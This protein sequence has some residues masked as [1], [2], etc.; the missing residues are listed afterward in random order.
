[1]HMRSKERYLIIPND[2]KMN[3]YN[4]DSFILPLKNF[5]VGFD[6]YFEIDEINKFSSIY[7][8][9]IIINKLLHKDDLEKI[10]LELSKLSSNIKYIFI[11][12]FSLINYLPKDKI[13]IYP[14]HIITNYYS[15]NYLNEL[16]FKNVCV[17][18]ELTINELKEINKNVNSNLFY[19][20]LSKNSLMY[21]KRTLLTNYFD[22]YELNNRNNSILVNELVSNHELIIK[23]EPDATNVFNN[24]IFCASKYLS[25]L[26]DY[27]LIINLSNIN[28]EEKK[29]I[30]DNINNIELYKLIDS[31]F[32]FLE[33]K[34]MYKVG[35]L[36]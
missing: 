1:M 6:T 13:V 15:V 22:K 31:D 5:S 28:E 30:L 4:N 9:S 33:N 19:M 23:E 7:N 36:K 2:K 11:E 27:N 26:K 32:Y 18:N 24:K 21:S 17:S 10:K 20:Y 14:N 25:D 29:V 8:I 16:G 35:D 34:I 12:D 3:E